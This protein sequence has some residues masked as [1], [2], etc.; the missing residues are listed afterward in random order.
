MTPKQRELARHAL[1][2]K[3]RNKKSF[4]NYF[5]VDR[6]SAYWDEW[7]RMEQA[8]EAKRFDGATLA[9]GGRDLFKLTQ[10]GAERA[11]N[12]DEKLDPEDF[13]VTQKRKANAASE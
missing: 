9:F 12:H 1:G 8:G 10:V 4:R 3:D 2:L 5:V 13:P 6:A 7:S 11:L